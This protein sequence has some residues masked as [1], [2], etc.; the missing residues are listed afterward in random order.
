MELRVGIL[1]LRSEIQ[2]K[3][4]ESDASSVPLNVI[5]ISENVKNFQKYLTVSF[6]LSSFCGKLNLF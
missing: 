1:P 4:L 3:K 5:R 2:S 6:F